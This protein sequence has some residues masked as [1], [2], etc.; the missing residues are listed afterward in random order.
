MKKIKINKQAFREWKDIDS[1]SCYASYYENVQLV[2]LGVNG[3]G[4]YQLRINKK[5]IEAFKDID[6]AIAAYEKWTN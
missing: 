4:L 5:A 3:N 2:E 1:F 6:S